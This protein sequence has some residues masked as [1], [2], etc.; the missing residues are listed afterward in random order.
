MTSV[1]P[2]FKKKAA[3]FLGKPRCL[4][5]H[6]A[7]CRSVNSTH[8]ILDAH[9]FRFLRNLG[10]S[11]EIAT[12]LLNHG[13]GDLIERM[14]LRSYLQ[15]GRRVLLR[16]PPDKS[17]GMTTPQRIRCVLE[18]LGPTF[19]KFGQVLSTRPDLAPPEI[20][21]EL[22][23][24]QEHVPPFSSKEAIEA[25][26]VLARICTDQSIASFLNRNGMLTG[27][28]IRPGSR[29]WPGGGIALG[30][31]SAPPSSLASNRA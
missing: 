31:G 3:I 24:L 7:P 14:G 30:L 17:H 29:S 12:V 15:W 20:I 26:R 21:K 22:A 27:R 10:R 19:I 23:H 18:D 5:K 13:F 1:S 16:K 4:L 8:S 11:R 28:G 25:V 6:R 2:C 9:P